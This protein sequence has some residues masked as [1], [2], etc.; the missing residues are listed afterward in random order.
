MSIHAQR[1]P[2][3]AFSFLEPRKNDFHGHGLDMELNHSTNCFWWIQKPRMAQRLQEGK[4][5]SQHALSSHT[6]E[7]MNQ[8][9]TEQDRT[10]KV[11]TQSPLAGCCSI[12]WIRASLVAQWL[13][14]HL[15]MQGTRVR[16]LV[17]ED[18]TCRGAT[19]PLHHNYWACALESTS[20]NYSARVPQLLSP[21]A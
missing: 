2:L 12:D 20:H 3:Q 6:Q 1:P 14:I 18:P 7:L 9:Q 4:R 13:R 15:P 8:G 21:R 17:Q 10:L 19:K 11:N 5:Q 16:A